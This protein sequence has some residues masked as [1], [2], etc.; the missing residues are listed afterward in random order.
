M[1]D[2]VKSLFSGGSSPRVRGKRGGADGVL[3][4]CGLIPARAGKT[5][6]RYAGAHSSGAHPRACG[7]NKIKGL[8]PDIQVGSSPRVRG[9]RHR[10]CVGWSIIRLI[11]ARAGKTRSTRLWRLSR[12]AHPRACGENRPAPS[13]PGAFEGS[14]PR[15]R[16][17]RGP[18]SAT[19]SHARLIPARAG[20]TSTSST[21]AGT[22]RAH[23][24]ACGENVEP[25]AYATGGQGSSPR[26]RGK[27]PLAP[28]LAGVHGL[29]PARAGKT[30]S[31]P[32]PPRARRA[33]PRACGENECRR[34]GSPRGTG[35]S[36][37]VRG[38]PGGRR[39]DRR[40][41]GLIPARAGKTPR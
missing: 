26:V 39:G 32:P 40:V 34:T 31:S 20:K 2:W 15:V 22:P 5:H 12:R 28:L 33:H 38:K 14:S 41:A 9:K 10:G 4:V 1:Y 3:T 25:I 11:P 18:V 30:T 13:R 23:P 27:H 37:R 7:E 35:S 17:K 21:P 16:G 8:K 29:I 19:D 6:E 24:R 36:P